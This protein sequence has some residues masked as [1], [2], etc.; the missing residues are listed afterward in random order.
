MDNPTQNKINCFDAIRDVMA[1]PA[2][3]AAIDSNQ[4]FKDEAEDFRDTRAV[5]QPFL[6]VAAGDTKGITTNKARLRSALI[7]KLVKLTGGGFG[8]AKKIGNAELET[9]MD[10]NKTDWNKMRG[11]EIETEA[12]N[13]HDALEAV[14]TADD[15]A[16]PAP[17]TPISNYQ[18]TAAAL[19]DLQMNIDAL[20][21]V[22]EGPRAKRAAISGASKQVT[23]LVAQ[24]DDKKAVLKRL[25]PQLEDSHPQFVGAMQTAMVIVDSAA[26]RPAPKTPSPPH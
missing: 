9:A 7:K 25:L 24:L 2:N 3:A 16:S 22:E 23:A 19:N 18:V 12:Q 17:A 6:Q 15:A 21:L 4:G 1:D 8:Y 10:K 20:S 5:L 13:V 14:V 11:G 26:T